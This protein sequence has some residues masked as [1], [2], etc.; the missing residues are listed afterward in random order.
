MRKINQFFDY[1]KLYFRVAT[2]NGEIE[3]ITNT[4][5]LGLKT[6]R[7]GNMDEATHQVTTN[8]LLEKLMEAKL[9]RRYELRIFVATYRFNNIKQ[10]LQ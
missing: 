1:L 10:A 4:L 2:L 5:A 6:Y 3:S 8:M 7:R 9:E